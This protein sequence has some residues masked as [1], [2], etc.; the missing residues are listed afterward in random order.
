MIALEKILQ[1]RDIFRARVELMRMLTELSDEA[2]EYVW[3]PIAYAYYHTDNHDNNV[4]SDEDV[5]R[6]LLVI[7]VAND[8]AEI[9]QTVACCRAAA[10]QEWE[11]KKRGIQE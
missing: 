6:I 9:V 10:C 2:L 11:A 1:E 3:R 7:S 4:L 8:P 5:H